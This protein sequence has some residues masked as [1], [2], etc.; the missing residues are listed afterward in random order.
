MTLRQFIDI[1]I[2]QKDKHNSDLDNFIKTLVIFCGDKQ[3]ESDILELD[4]D[5]FSKIKDAFEWIKSEPPK[6][7]NTPSTFEIDG[8]TFS[9][10]KDYQK[11]TVG[12][13]ISAELL[14]KDPT[15]D[16][17]PLEI[18]FAILFREVGPD[19]K[20][21]DFDADEMFKMLN[22]YSKRIKIVDVY[23]VITFFLSSEKNSSTKTS[24]VSLQVH[25]AEKK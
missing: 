15:F 11:L 18:S 3:I 10:K 12:E 19:G 2:L 23:E 25:Q 1:L 22:D 4:M 8:K 5:D 14:L 13:A 17:D 24:A 16:L 20:M 6:K 7:E 9:M 21:K